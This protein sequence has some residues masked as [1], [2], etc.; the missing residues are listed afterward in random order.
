MNTV[1]KILTGV[2]AFLGILILALS[3]LYFTFSPD[4]K[5]QATAAQEELNAAKKETQSLQSELDTI[6]ATADKERTLMLANIKALATAV[7]K[8]N[9]DIT[10]QES[11]R[12]DSEKLLQE[13]LSKMAAASSKLKATQEM[14]DGLLKRVGATK[15]E[16]D[17]NFDLVNRMTDELR[18]RQAELDALTVENES[19]TAETNRLRGIVEK[20]GVDATTLASEPLP[21]DAHVVEV[22]D[23]DQGRLVAVSAGSDQGLKVGNTL[24]VYRKSDGTARYLGRIEIVDVQADR[25]SC[26]VLPEFAKDA[27]QQGD[28]VSVSLQ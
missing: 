4:W 15:Q 19:L 16:R 21:L 25:C 14:R 2:V 26:R 12:L 5:G 7:E 13:S 27:V 18:Q 8:G 10:K 23:T 28:Q 20:E 22:L 9:A 24:E 3:V 6:N 11:E 17:R 1:G